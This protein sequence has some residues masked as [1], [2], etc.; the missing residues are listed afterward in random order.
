MFIRASNVLPVATGISVDTDHVRQGDAGDF[1]ARNR[2]ALDA[3]IRQSRAELASGVRSTCGI[4]A[5]FQ[6]GRRRHWPG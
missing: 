3:S 6:D 2:D 5:I 1:I 4:E